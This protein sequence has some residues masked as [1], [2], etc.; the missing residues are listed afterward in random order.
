MW[1]SNRQRGSVRKLSR[2]TASSK[3]LPNIRRRIISVPVFFRQLLSFFPLSLPYHSFGWRLA[4]G[5]WT[6][7]VVSASWARPLSRSGRVRKILPILGLDSRTVHLVASRCTDLIHE[8]S[9]CYRSALMPYWLRHRLLM[10]NQ[11]TVELMG[12]IFCENSSFSASTESPRLLW[13][14]E[15]HYHI[16]Y[17]VSDVFTSCESSLEILIWKQTR[18]LAIDRRMMSKRILRI[19]R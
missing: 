18:D 1:D 17:V 6:D 16:H 2:L 12:Q 10:Q 15:I 11:L 7:F 14:A 5:I 9:Y 3:G 8:Q 4:L 13:N 19:R